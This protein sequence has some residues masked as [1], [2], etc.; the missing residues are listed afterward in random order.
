VAKVSV[1]DSYG[2]IASEAWDRLVGEGSPFLEH[3]FL[4]GL[5]R[6]GCAVPETGWG[7][8]PV[9]VHDDD[10]VLVGA[11]PG[12]VK[13]HSMG[14]FV[15]D[16][17]WADAAR[18]AGI[19][20]FPKLVVGVPFSPVTGQRLLVAPGA[21][22]EAVHDALLAGLQEAARGTYG[23]HVLFDTE[24][25]AEALERRGAFTRLQ[26][27][28]H[29]NNAGYESF[30]DFLGRFPS[31]KRNKIRRER[32]ELRGLRIEAVT[33]P[34]PA[35]LDAMYGFYEGHCRQFGPWGRVYLSR[36]FFHHLGEV[37]GDRLHLVL[38]HD[39]ERP[40]A[41]TFNV[42]KGERLY[43]RH[44]GAEDDVRFLHF[45]VCYYQAIDECIRRGLKVFEPGHGGGHK[46]RR[47]FEPTLTR[48]SHWLA[49]PGLHE[50]LQRHTEGEARA[51]R[52]QQEE[53]K[54][55]SPLR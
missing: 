3:A 51:V 36:D 6:L 35:Q 53:L 23:L 42:L 50:A 16:H 13:S 17:G 1:L 48:S 9:V 27:Q 7:P 41:G 28:F 47:G 44:W 11:A 54:A 8:R 52:A 2:S 21:D 4:W 39:G 55:Q 10:G 29:W 5:E 24:A 15:Y 25:E 49:H 37:W 34:S 14:E 33:R 40:V 12:W 30:E 18:R 22:A 26:Y 20:Y 19:P 32:K 46:Y 43:G 38:A 45:E 31:K